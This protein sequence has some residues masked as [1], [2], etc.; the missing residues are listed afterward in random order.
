MLQHSANYLRRHFIGN[1]LTRPI[2]AAAF[3]QP[4]CLALSERNFRKCYSCLAGCHLLPLGA[5]LASRS[6]APYIRNLYDQPCKPSAAA[7]IAVSGSSEQEMATADT[8]LLCQLPPVLRQAA[9]ASWSPHLISASRLIASPG[10]G[11]SAVRQGG[12]GDHVEHHVRWRH[13]LYGI[14]LMP[15]RCMATAWQKGR[16]QAVP[17]RSPDSFSKVLNL[18][19]NISQVIQPYSTVRHT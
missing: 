17:P 3:P 7:C 16:A 8:S 13:E 10:G 15:R 12:W 2:A 6:L 11:L 18:R 19:T 1:A 9:A 14:G 4:P 5:R